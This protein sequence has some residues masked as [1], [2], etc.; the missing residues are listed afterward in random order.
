[1]AARCLERPATG[2]SADPACILDD[3][4]CVVSRSSI[5]RYCDGSQA[6]EQQRCSVA[7]NG[8][9]CTTMRCIF[10]SASLSCNAPFYAELLENP[11]AL[12]QYDARLQALEP[13]VVGACP[14]SELSRYPLATPHHG[15]AS[16]LALKDS[17]LCEKPV[18]KHCTCEVPWFTCAPATTTTVG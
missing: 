1:M 10:S 2:C 18:V 12:L 5:P 16:G 3:G 6:Q 15:A 11:Q 7:A 17:T 14:A 9:A 4:V 8:N 13:E